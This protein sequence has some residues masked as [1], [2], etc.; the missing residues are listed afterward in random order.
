M[1]DLSNPLAE[2]PP[3]DF[4][5]NRWTD[6]IDFRNWLEQTFGEFPDGVYYLWS[7]CYASYT[8]KRKNRKNKVG[9]PQYAYSNQRKERYYLKPWRSKAGKRTCIGKF[10]LED[11]EAVSIPERREKR[12]RK[13]YG[14]PKYPVIKRIEWNA[15]QTGENDY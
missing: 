11:G 8:Q 3:E 1:V 15:N 2:I 10:I 5:V 14:R 13:P 4:P 12:K 9:R 7:Y 6:K